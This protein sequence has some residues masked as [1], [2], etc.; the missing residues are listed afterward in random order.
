MEAALLDTM[1]EL[2]SI[3]DLRRVIVTAEAI[4]GEG[5]PILEFAQARKKSA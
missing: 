1:Y 5:K 4:R 3:A 2:P